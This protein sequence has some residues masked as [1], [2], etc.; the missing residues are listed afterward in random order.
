MPSKDISSPM[1]NWVIEELRYKAKLFDDIG[2]VT[3]Y[4]G[5]VVKSDSVILESLKLELQAAVTELENVPDKNK[6]WHPGSNGKVLDLVHPSLYPLV[7]GRTRVLEKGRISLEDCIARCGEGQTTQIPPR[8]EVAEFIKSGWYY[9]VLIPYSRV[10]QWLPCMVD[11]SGEH[12]KYV[13]CDDPVSENLTS[14]INRITSY[15]N[16]LHPLNKVLYRLIER[17][18]DAAIPLWNLTLGPLE[19]CDWSS[20]LRVHYNRSFQYFNDVIDPE[21]PEPDVF[22]P[23]TE[24]DSTIDLKKEYAESGLQIIVKL[25]NIHLTPENPTYEGGSWHV[26]GQRVSFAYLYHFRAKFD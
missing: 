20:Y 10:F 17:V 19:S 26:E 25:E 5:H 7:Y 2:A 15:I 22:D 13:C 8:E 4:T 14:S 24:P 1:M 9:T 3:V 21:Q 12:C 11:I 23:P 6:D 18:I 16:N